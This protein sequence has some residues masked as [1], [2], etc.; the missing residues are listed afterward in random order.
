MAVED[1]SGNGKIRTV[2]DIML[3]L[4]E[5]I[6]QVKSGEIKEAAAR[7]VMRGRGYQLKAVELF[8]QATRQDAQLRKQLQARMGG[9]VIDLKEQGPEKIEPPKE[10]PEHP[11]T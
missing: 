7:I 10:E 1:L 3:S 6:A 5:E 4:E 11:N 8:L 2:S 9:V